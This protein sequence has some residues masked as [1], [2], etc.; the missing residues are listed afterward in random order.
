[1]VDEKFFIEFCMQQSPLTFFIHKCMHIKIVL[2]YL[3][4]YMCMNTYITS[5]ACEQQMVIKLSD[6]HKSKANFKLRKFC[7]GV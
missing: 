1:M 4:L 5:G 3:S 6:H 7:L 2:V